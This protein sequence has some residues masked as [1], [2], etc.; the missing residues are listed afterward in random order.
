V[1]LVWSALAVGIVAVGA[2]AVLVVVRVVELWRAVRAFFSALGRGL[3][4]LAQRLDALSSYESSEL[5]RLEVSLERLRRSRAELSILRNALG[6][7]R[8]QASGAL[9]LYPRK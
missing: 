5:E 1:T 6:R 8:E 3:D 2:A 7:V 9:A 4:E